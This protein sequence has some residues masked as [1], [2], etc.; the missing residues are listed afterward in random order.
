M[1]TNVDH[2]YK[3]EV[4]P[5]FGIARELQALF[6]PV[7]HRLMLEKVIRKATF[8]YDREK[9]ANAL[10]G[11]IHKITETPQA[12][13]GLNFSFGWEILFLGDPADDETSY[14]L[15]Y[16]QQSE[17][18]E[19]WEQTPGVSPYPYWD[20]ADRPEGISSN[21]WE[22]RKNVWARMLPD[23]YTPPT[24][25]LTWRLETASFP[26][27]ELIT[28]NPDAALRMVPDRTVR[29]IEVAKRHIPDIVPGQ[30]GAASQGFLS[31]METRQLWVDAHTP[32]YESEL[33]DVSLADLGHV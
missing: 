15:V 6:E 4:T 32:K 20:D 27:S 12:A 10:S 13:G 31:L 23:R 14:A 11:S 7:Y 22:H 25:G 3:L 24:V 8:L 29:A 9:P 33:A 17:Y 18:R 5:G 16:G 26:L 30:T 1:P 28:D 21:E 19:V 2:G